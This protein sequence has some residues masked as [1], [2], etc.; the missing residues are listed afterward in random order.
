ME[1][2]APLTPWEKPDIKIGSAHLPFTDRIG[3]LALRLTAQ[4]RIAG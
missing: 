2:R 1:R 3:Q 4:V